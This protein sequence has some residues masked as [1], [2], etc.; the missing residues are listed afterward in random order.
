MSTTWAT[1]VANGPCTAGPSTISHMR[2]CYGLTVTVAT[3][4]HFPFKQW[5][6]TCAARSGRR[7]PCIQ[8]HMAQ[9]LLCIAGAVRRACFHCFFN[10]FVLNLLISFCY[11]V[12][13]M[14]SPKPEA[15]SSRAKSCMLALAGQDL[16]NF[17]PPPQPTPYRRTAQPGGAPVRTRVISVSSIGR[18]TKNGFT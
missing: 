12:L 7:K 9:V 14:P 11:T 17:E 2:I 18:C 16:L 5:C 15:G 4:F 3:K 13:T 8:A 6:T 1:K 10:S